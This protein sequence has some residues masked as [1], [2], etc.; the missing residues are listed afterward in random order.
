M[1]LYIGN[2]QVEVSGQAEIRQLTVIYKNNPP[3]ESGPQ[4]GRIYTS[5]TTLIVI[6]R[7]GRYWRLDED[8]SEDGKQIAGIYI[9]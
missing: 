6:D 7:E 2:K 1:N 4:Q 5:A 3:V 9:R 8:G